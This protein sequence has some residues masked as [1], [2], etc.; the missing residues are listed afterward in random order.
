MA[1]TG[2][3]FSIASY[4]RAIP[5]N[6]RGMTLVM[7]AAISVNV[8][9]VAIR[10]IKDDVH[11]YEI[12]FIRHV[13]SFLLFSPIFLRSGTAIF[14]TR[15]F[16]MLMLRA[17]LN[18]I[19]M[20]IYFI[21]V[22]LIPM[23]EVTALGF[24][25]PLFVAVL[26]VFFL[27]E[28]MTTTRLAGLLIGLAGALI[29]LRPGVQTIAWGSVCILLSS[30]TWAFALI[31]I[32][33]LTRTES[34]LTIAMYAALL[35]MP[36]SFI[37]ALFVWTWPDAYS[38]FMIF[39]IAICGSTAHLTVAQAFRDADATVVMPVDFT[40]IIWASVAGYLFFAEVPDVL[41]LVGGVIVF[42]GVIYI[43]FRERSAK[44]AGG[45]H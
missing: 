17:V 16:G 35:Q 39:L 42:T 13:F 1:T 11:I 23:S 32:K 41:T 15:R 8:M 19:A 12:G 40:K 31:V 34:T 22:T 45:A 10:E 36:F 38:L 18:V 2:I 9:V 3:S 7:I 28:R 14:V 29:I 4:Y 20:F 25:T 24:T 37:P 21:G 43:A 27:N 5:A 6:I 30:S 26:A 44:P 33:K